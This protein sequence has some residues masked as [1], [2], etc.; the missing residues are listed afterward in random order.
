VTHLSIWWYVA[1]AIGGL[2]LWATN[3]WAAA[4]ARQPKDPSHCIDC[5]SRLAQGEARRCALCSEAHERDRAWTATMGQPGG[6]P[7]EFFTL[8]AQVEADRKARDRRRWQAKTGTQR[9]AAAVQKSIYL[10]GATLVVLAIGAWWL[11]DNTAP[12]GADCSPAEIR[13]GDCVPS[14][15][16]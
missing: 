12:A 11:W 7:P 8:S 1:A 10:I 3:S 16:R 15:D 9:L 14:R 13:Y 5:D 6:H 4:Q 2:L